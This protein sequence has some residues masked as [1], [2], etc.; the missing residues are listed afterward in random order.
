VEDPRQVE[1]SAMLSMK[2]GRSLLV[3]LYGRCREF[4]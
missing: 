2:F 3:Y 1:V 4:G